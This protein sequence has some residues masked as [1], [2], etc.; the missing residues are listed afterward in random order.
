MNRVLTPLQNQFH[1]CFQIIQ[2]SPATEQSLSIF[3]D[4]TEHHVNFEWAPRRPT[5]PVPKPRCSFLISLV[6]GLILQH[7]PC[8]SVDS[9]VRWNKRDGWLV[10]SFLLSSDANEAAAE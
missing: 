8:V 1:S 10:V 9:Q 3:G 6:I 7:K 5:V 2:A 4:T